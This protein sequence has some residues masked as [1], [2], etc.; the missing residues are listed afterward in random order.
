MSDH[1][2]GLNFPLNLFWLLKTLNCPWN[3]K[4]VSGYLIGQHNSNL[5]NQIAETLSSNEY[6]VTTR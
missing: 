3:S 1:G 5:A 6:L 2:T 4:L